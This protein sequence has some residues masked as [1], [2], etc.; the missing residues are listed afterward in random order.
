MTESGLLNTTAQVGGALGLAVLATL[1]SNRTGELLAQGQSS[2]SALSG[3]YHLAWAIGARLVVATIAL[4]ATLLKSETAAEAESSM[5]EEEASSPQEASEMTQQG[6]LSRGT[7]REGHDHTPAFSERPGDSGAPK[8]RPCSTEHPT[9]FR[10]V[11]A[12]WA[13]LAVALEWGGRPLHLW[14]V[15]PA[16]M[17]EA[18]TIAG[19]MVVLRV[20]TPRR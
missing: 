18:R 6:G 19:R 4:A 7:D 16:N 2:T 3:G 17:L 20:H 14:P 12:Y 5:Q 11:D 9:L 15:W 1:A 13:T 8:P 10:S